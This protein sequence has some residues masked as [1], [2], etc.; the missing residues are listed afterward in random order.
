MS[1]N[2]RPTPPTNDGRDILDQV[3][4]AL[5]KALWRYRAEV[6]LLAPVVAAFAVADRE[7]GTLPAAVLVAGGAGLLVVA[8]RTRRCLSSF[9]SSAYWRRRVETALRLLSK[10]RF[11]G[12]K[13]RVSRARRT[14]VG[15]TALVHLPPGCAPSE[16]T[17]SAERLA[18]ALRAREVRLE[19]DKTNANRLFFTVLMKGPF[20]GE[21]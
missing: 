13:F 14:A 1:S 19:R 6:A 4:A 5:A 2:T 8:P 21:P 17:A 3:I 18:S 11:G 10:E 7:L 15:A 9:L 12:R 16:V 20:E